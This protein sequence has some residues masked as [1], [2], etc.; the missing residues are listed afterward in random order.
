MDQGLHGVDLERGHQ[1][2]GAVTSCV[3]AWI[4]DKSRWKKIIY[5]VLYFIFGVCLGDSVLLSLFK[6]IYQGFVS[7]FLL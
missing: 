3:E 2:K 5:L 7:S 4:H 6:Y 1:D